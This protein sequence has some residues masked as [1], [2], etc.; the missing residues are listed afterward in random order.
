LKKRQYAI[1]QVIERSFRDLDI[2]NDIVARWRPLNGKPSIVIDPARAFGQPIAAD[3]GVPTT[4]IAD[5]VNSE[6]S[7]DRVARLFAV[8]LP[9]VRDAVRFEETLLEA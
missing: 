7:I 5:A 3:S 1:K 2:A 9:V 6:G 4:V 8:P